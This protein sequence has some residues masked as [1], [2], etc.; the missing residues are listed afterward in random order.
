MCLVQQAVG[1]GTNSL[2][3]SYSIEASPTSMIISFKYAY[4]ITLFG[5][6]EGLS[7]I[8]LRLP[9][10]VCFFYL[11]RGIFKIKLKILKTAL[12]IITDPD[13]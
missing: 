5:M 4:Q 2:L 8:P 11:K 7:L 13:L 9:G 1:F 3:R 10:F 6:R 12:F